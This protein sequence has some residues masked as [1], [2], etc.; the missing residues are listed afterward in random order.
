MQRDEFEEWKRAEQ[1]AEGADKAA[2]TAA[3]AGSPDAGDLAK[4]VIALRKHA[5]ALWLEC[6]GSSLTPLSSDAPVKSPKVQAVDPATIKARI[7]EW[8]R[9]QARANVAEVRAVHACMRYVGG[10]EGERP[11]LAVAQASMLRQRAAERLQRVFESAGQPH[12]G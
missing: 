8:R 11:P 2:R 1:A 10:A 12:S 7:E 3:T 5:N 6:L 4:S 9:A